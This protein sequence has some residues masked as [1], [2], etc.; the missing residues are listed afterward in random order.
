MEVFMR[1]DSGKLLIERLEMTAVGYL[2]ARAL[3]VMQHISHVA[4]PFLYAFV[5]LCIFQFI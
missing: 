2:L 4:F 3:R 5:R 1:L